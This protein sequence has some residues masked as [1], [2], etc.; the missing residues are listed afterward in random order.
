MRIVLEHIDKNEA[1]LM[2]GGF[3][4]MLVDSLQVSEVDGNLKLTFIHLEDGNMR[5]KAVQS[6]VRWRIPS[7]DGQSALDITEV[8]Q[9][10]TIVA[11]VGT[12]D[13]SCYVVAETWTPKQSK[14]RG[15]K[16]EAQYW[17]E[18][19]IVSPLIE[20]LFRQNKSLEFGQKTEYTAATLQA[21]LFRT[22]YGP[23]IEMVKLMDQMGHNEN[24][25]AP[26]SPPKGVEIVEKGARRWAP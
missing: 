2:F 21:G 14:D 16:G 11:S 9:L 20:A 25:H 12:S 13:K 4:K 24:N 6:C 10:D 26:W 15:A 3:A 18:A 23:A 19:S 22:L 7:R 5:V 1:D 8:E 17:Y